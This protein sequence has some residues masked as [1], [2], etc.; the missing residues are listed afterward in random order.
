MVEERLFRLKG[1]RREGKERSEEKV[2][3]SEE[4]I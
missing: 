4:K 3:E 2:E 1:M